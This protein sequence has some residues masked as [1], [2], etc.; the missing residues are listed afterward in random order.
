MPRP[1]ITS[2]L[3]Q[4]LRRR[5]RLEPSAAASAPPAPEDPLLQLGRLLRQKREEQGLS[6]RQLATETRISTPVIEALERGWRDRLPEP[7][8]LRTMLALLEQHLGLEPGALNAALPLQAHP[9]DDHSKQPSLLRRF[10][11]GSIDVFTSW[12]GTVLYGLLTAG[13][14]YAV[15]LQQQQLAAANQ[16][17]LRPVPPL[18]EAERVKPPDSNALLL[19]VH[20]DLRPLQQAARGVAQKQ[21]SREARQ[22]GGGP[23]VLR[24]RLDQPT[25]LQLSSESGEGTRLQGA[26]GSLVL[27]MQPPL[28]VQLT[29]PPAAGS[30]AVRWNEQPLEAEAGRPGGYRVPPA[31]ARGSAAAPAALPSVAPPADLP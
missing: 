8:Y 12:Q 20:P 18:T 3:P 19:Q 25:S 6:L 11:P 29:P 1:R 7:A 27:Q 16:L 9:L 5:L 10:T 4:A 31:A 14:I 30:G 13:L 2:L 23:G 24:L 21:W 28:Q 17:T 15:N 22:E 26:R